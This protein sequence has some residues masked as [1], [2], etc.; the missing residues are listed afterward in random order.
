MTYT[1]L[2]PSYLLGH[3]NYGSGVQVEVD[4]PTK[5]RFKAEGPNEPRCRTQLSKTGLYSL[6]VFIKG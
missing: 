6:S 1:W 3:D 5:A 4:G 2:S